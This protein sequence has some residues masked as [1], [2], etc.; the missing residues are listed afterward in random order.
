M[1]KDNLVKLKLFRPGMGGHVENQ[2]V[3][4]EAEDFINSTEVDAIEI[5][6]SYAYNNG[7]ACLSVFV[8]YRDMVV[9]KSLAKAAVDATEDKKKSAKKA[10]TKKGAPKKAPKK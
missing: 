4:Q 8:T 5:S 3:V 6:H 7:N 10:D 2:E 9:A 1:K